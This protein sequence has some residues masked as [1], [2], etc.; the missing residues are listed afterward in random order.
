MWGQVVPNYRYLGQNG[1]PQRGEPGLTPTMRGAPR[2]GV[3]IYFTQKFVFGALFSPNE[4]VETHLA[5]FLDKLV[6]LSKKF[7]GRSLLQ[8][9]SPVAGTPCVWKNVF[10]SFLIKTRQDQVLMFMGKFGPTALNFG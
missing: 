9:K 6:H 8:A 5:P 3:L 10:W 1:P 7:A 4:L 2:S